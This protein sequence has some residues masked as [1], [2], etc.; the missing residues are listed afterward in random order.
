MQAQ[1][2]DK[3]VSS[4][5]KKLFDSNKKYFETPLQEFTYWDKYSRWIP[6]LSRREVWP[7]TVD[8][9]IRFLKK[10]CAVSF[11]PVE[12]NE[13]HDAMLS[14]K[15]LPSMRILQM[16]PALERCNV[17]SYNCSFA[18]IDSVDSIAELLYILMQGTGAGYSVEDRYVGK[19]PRV[20]R[21]KRVAV[22]KYTIPDTT[23]GWCDALKLGINTWF[24]GND[25]QFDFSKIR[26]A[27]ALLLTKGGRAS[28]PQPLRDLLAFVRSTVLQAQGRKLT[29]LEVHD[30]CCYCGFVVQVGGVRRSALISL[31]DF[32]DTEIAKCKNGEFWNRFPYRAMSNNSAVHEEKP[33]AVDFMEEWLNLAKSGTGERGMF[34][35][36]CA[37]PAR[38]K[39]SEFGTNPCSEIILKSNQMCNLSIVVAREDDTLKDLLAKIRIATMF[40]TAQTTLTHFPYLNPKYERNCSEERLLGVDIT[41]QRDCKLLRDDTDTVLAACRDEAVRINKELSERF[42]INQSAAVTCVKPSGN[43]AALLN[44]SSG[45]HVRY[46]PYYIRRVR[47]GAYTPIAKLLID[48]GVPYFPETGQDAENASVLVFEFPVKSPDGAVC[49]GDVSAK[50]QFDYWLFNRIHY[51]EHAPS[52]FSAKTRFVTSTGVRSFEGCSDME[53]VNILNK[54]GEFTGATVNR[55]GRQRIWEL[56]VERCGVQKIIETTQ[57]H[58]WPVSYPCGRYFGYKPRLVRTDDLPIGKQLLTVNPVHRPPL[59]KTAVLH[60]L[61]FGDGSKHRQEPGNGRIERGQIYLYNDPKGCDNRKLVPLFVAA[62]Y[63]PIEKNYR[64]HT[65]IYGLPAEWKDLPNNTDASYIRGFIAGWFGADGHIDKSGNCSIASAVYSNLEWLQ[66]MAPVAGLAVSTKITA[67]KYG[68]ASFGGSDGECY[69]ITLSKDTVDLAFFVSPEKAARYKRAKFLKYWKIKS[70]RATGRYED[71]WCVTVPSGHNFVLDGNILTHNCTIYVEESEW[72]SLGCLVYDNWDS[73]SGLS[74]L[75][76][77]HHIYPLAPY[78]EVSVDEYNQ[79]VAEFPCIDWSRL[80][81]YEQADSTTVALDYACVANSCDL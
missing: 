42:G 78:Q 74:F 47:A 55:F 39:P 5:I 6:E 62:G 41:G 21:Q 31:S 33:S 49:R 28:G 64:E 40:G 12:W 32:E 79:R 50:D 14:L 81:Q 67:N 26:Q 77:D 9:V 44:C 51:T 25:I 63:K 70:V 65:R 73:I 29:P 68:D 59:N 75:P 69:A 43:S 58:L 34:N 37:I 35:R 17:G 57:D 19:L 10:N 53:S 11:T 45:L 61:V 80:I 2:V 72:L 71:V 56:V 24:S 16:S 60:G 54:N 3:P 7:E 27:G 15:A 30:I 66:S 52:C 13:M 1:Q 23:E 76:K 8:R 20:K 46:A 36:K 38:R 4:D 18:A 48:S 22:L